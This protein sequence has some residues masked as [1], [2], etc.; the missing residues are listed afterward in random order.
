MSL[1]RNLQPRDRTQETKS[2]ETST[3]TNPMHQVIP[4]SSPKVIKEG[5]TVT[6]RFDEQENLSDDSQEEAALRLKNTKLDYHQGAMTTNRSGHLK[7]E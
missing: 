4:C 7:D 3:Q 5:T 2:V 1:T 6:L